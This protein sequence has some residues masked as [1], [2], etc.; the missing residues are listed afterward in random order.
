[1]TLS[2]SLYIRGLQCE[3]SLWLK[4]KKPEVLQAPDDSAQAVFDT[5]TSVGELACELFCGGERM[6][7]HGLL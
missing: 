1:M 7:V 5:G 6:R 3:K 4:K 2:K